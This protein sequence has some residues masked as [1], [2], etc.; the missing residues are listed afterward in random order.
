METVKTVFKNSRVNIEAVKW[1][2]GSIKYRTEI[3]NFKE[4][5]KIYTDY[6]MFNKKPT[7]S[8][9]ISICSQNFDS[10]NLVKLARHIA[11][12]QNAKILVSEIQEAISNFKF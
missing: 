9:N 5:I 1:E 10:S 4:D 2:N 8:I 12:I 3:D 11:E 7:L 6:D